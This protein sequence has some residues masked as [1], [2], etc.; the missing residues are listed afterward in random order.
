MPGLPLVLGL[1]DPVVDEC[2]DCDHGEARGRR[3]RWCGRRHERAPAGRARLLV[4]APPHHN[5]RRGPHPLINPRR[6]AAPL[7]ADLLETLKVQ[8]GGCTCVGAQEM[9]ALQAATAALAPPTRWE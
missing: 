5:V 7:P 6:H 4:R 1:G 2:V 8:P 9:V 3:Y